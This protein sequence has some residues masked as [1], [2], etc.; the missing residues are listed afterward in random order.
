V[1]LDAL[2]SPSF[3]SLVLSNA[4]F[5]PIFDF[6]RIL[7]WYQDLLDS[8]NITTSK[9]LIL[10]GGIKKWN[11]VYGHNEKCLMRL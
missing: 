6:L 10:T 3:I 11:E 4:A 7:G 2:V 8:N 1:V 5:D 9:A